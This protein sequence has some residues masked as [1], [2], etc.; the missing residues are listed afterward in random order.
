MVR[1]MLDGECVTEA[2][3]TLADA[4]HAASTRAAEK[5]RLILEVLA[6]GHPLPGESLDQPESHAE[7]VAELSLTSADPTAFALNILHEAADAIEQA[8]ERQAVAA[9]VLEQGDITKAFEH[10]SI[11]LQLWDMIHQVVERTLGIAPPVSDEHRDAIN[12]QVI[13]LRD[14]LNELRDAVKAQDWA[15]LSDLIRYDMT[16]LGTSWTT[17]LRAWATGLRPSGGE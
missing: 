5:G 16:E 7:P 2:S 11:S 15:A 6:D 13:Q 4:L 17:M 9:D 8:R 1:V 12:E 3:P 14:R 10:L